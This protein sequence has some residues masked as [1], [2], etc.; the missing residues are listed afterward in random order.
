MVVESESVKTGKSYFPIVVHYRKE[1]EVECVVVMS[2][3]KLRQGVP[4]T[5]VEVN[6]V[7]E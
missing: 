4:F 5:V 3:E 6:V 7:I 1:D 2:P